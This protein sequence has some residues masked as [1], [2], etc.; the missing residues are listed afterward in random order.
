MAFCT[1][2]YFVSS[3]GA[4]LSQ[5]SL[6]SIKPGSPVRAGSRFR[7]M[8]GWECGGGNLRAT[9]SAQ[10]T[11]DRYG[12]C[13]SQEAIFRERSYGLVGQPQIYPLQGGC[14]CLKI[15]HWVVSRNIN[16]WVFH[17]SLISPNLSALCPVCMQPACDIMLP[18]GYTLCCSI[19]LLWPLLDFQLSSSLKLCSLEECIYLILRNTFVYIHVLNCLAL[20]SFFF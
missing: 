11:W 19:S 1:C 6:V 7:G 10:V 13:I 15:I 14:V 5:G 3:V 12:C 9:G 18:L 2:W 4:F 17:Y 8:T 16:V 20:N